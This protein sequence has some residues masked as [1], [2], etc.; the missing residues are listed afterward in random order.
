MRVRVAHQMLFLFI[1]PV[2]VHHCIRPPLNLS[3]GG[4]ASESQGALAASLT[5]VFSPTTRTP[6]LPLHMLTPTRPQSEVI[7]E[8]STQAALG[9]VSV[10]QSVREESRPYCLGALIWVTGLEISTCNHCRS[11]AEA[12]HP[13]HVIT[14]SLI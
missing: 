7:S 2:A 9:C 3:V 10:I 13:D 8:H 11:Q 4:A 1:S 6:L 14:T 12:T 5:I